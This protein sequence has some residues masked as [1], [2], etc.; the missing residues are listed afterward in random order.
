MHIKTAT[1]TA[2]ADPA[3]LPNP[4]HLSRVP[5]HIGVDQLARI[6]Q[7]A[8]ALPHVVKPADYVSEGSKGFEL[9]LD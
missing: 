7:S 1:A 5:L 9:H 4:K 3:H 8:F 6:R 2:N